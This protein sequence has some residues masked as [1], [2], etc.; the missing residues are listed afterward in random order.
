[1]ESEKFFDKNG[2]ELWDEF[3]NEPSATPLAMSEEE[4]ARFIAEMEALLSEA[5]KSN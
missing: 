2:K 4:V 3:E 5:P 1:M